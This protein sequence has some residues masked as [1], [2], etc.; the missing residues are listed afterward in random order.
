MSY[1]LVTGASGFIGR[2]LFRSLIAD[3]RAATGI[4]RK[5]PGS[6]GDWHA[7][8][9]AQDQALPA[10]LMKGTDTLYHLAALVHAGTPRGAAEKARLKRMNVDLPE[11]LARQAAAAGVRRLVFLSSIGAQAR[12]SGTLLDE[13][14][15][16]HP[17]DAYGASKLAAEEALRRIAAETGLEVAILRPPLVVGPGAPGNLARL[18]AW[19]R[20]GRPLPAATLANRRHMVGVT[21]LVAAL[22]LAAMHPAAAGETFIVAD[23]EPLSTG[24]LYRLLAE[25]AGRPARFLPLPAPPLAWALKSTG[26]AALAEG[27]F[28]DLL[29]DAG[30][31]RQRLGWQPARPLAEELRAAVTST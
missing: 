29:V 21:N 6:L 10:G 23:P 28:G 9:L 20:K 30:K 4:A 1:D 2:A 27:L 3:G 5:G 11:R 18:I 13:S 26:R 31:I 14:G 17:S 24:A 8:D 15:P 12:S 25:A 22:R 19:A 7:Q 16:C